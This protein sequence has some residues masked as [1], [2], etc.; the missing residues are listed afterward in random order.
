MTAAG[1]ALWLTVAVGGAAGLYGLHRLC[2]W[3]EAHGHLYYLHKKPEGSSPTACLTALQE[4]IEPPAKHVFHVREE[5]RYA[6]E[7]AGDP[8]DPPAK[9][10][11]G[12]PPAT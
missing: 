3:L 9:E 10:E 12:A 7:E 8:P 5:K 4:L 6:E 1:V 2:L 11:P